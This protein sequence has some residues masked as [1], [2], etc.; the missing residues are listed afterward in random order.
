[1]SSISHLGSRSYAVLLALSGEKRHGYDLMRQIAHD[2]NGQLTLGPATLY[3]TLKRLLDLGFITEQEETGGEGREARRRYYQLSA[4]GN[5]ALAEE[6]E[7]TER[8][9]KIAKQRMA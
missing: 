3:T 7:R 1:M 6:L 2:S 4:N 9:L 5:K 8:F